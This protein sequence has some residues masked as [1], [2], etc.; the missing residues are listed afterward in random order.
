MV[1]A[2][3]IEPMTRFQPSLFFTPFSFAKACQPLSGRL[4]CRRDR[5]VRCLFVRKSAPQAVGGPATEFATP[6]SFSLV[7]RLLSDL[8]LVPISATPFLWR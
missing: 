2:V 5:H 7:A 8:T 4:R 3:G 6:W 1:G